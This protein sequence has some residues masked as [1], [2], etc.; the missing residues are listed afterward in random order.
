[1]SLLDISSLSVAQ[2]QTDRS[3]IMNVVYKYIRCG[4]PETMYLGDVD[5]AI[6]EALA[7]LET[8][9]AAPMAIETNGKL[10]VDYLWLVQAF[11]DGLRDDRDPEVV[12]TRPTQNY[13]SLLN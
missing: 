8:R 4:K 13:N 9:Q 5:E 12:Y 6:Y 10:I 2:S 1:M 7:D 11:E 3:N